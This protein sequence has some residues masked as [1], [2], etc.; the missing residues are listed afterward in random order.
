MNEYEWRN[1]IRVVP[2]IERPDSNG[3]LNP[4]EIRIYPNFR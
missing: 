1:S 2:G 3:Y 4:T